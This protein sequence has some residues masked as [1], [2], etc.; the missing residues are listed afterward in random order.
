MKMIVEVIV[1]VH[2][3]EDDVKL[4]TDAAAKAVVQ[5]LGE[6]LRNAESRGFNHEHSDWVGINIDRLRPRAA[7]VLYDCCKCGKWIQIEKEGCV[8]ANDWYCDSCAERLKSK[9]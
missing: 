9:E 7:A 6:A 2:T 8:Y 5:G 4:S 1:D 3:L